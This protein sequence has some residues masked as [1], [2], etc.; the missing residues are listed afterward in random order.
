[1]IDA[2]L[3]RIADVEVIFVPVCG[4]HDWAM[5]LARQRWRSGRDQGND[6]SQNSEERSGGG[7]EADEGRAGGGEGCIHRR[8]RTGVV[9]NGGCRS[10]NAPCNTVTRVFSL[11]RLS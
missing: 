4:V 1:M 2:I 6:D 11:T 9:P 7:G 5:K 10:R 8:R 3:R